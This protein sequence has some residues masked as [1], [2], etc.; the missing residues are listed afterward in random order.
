MPA[1]KGAR[2]LEEGIEFLQS[3]EV[4]V[5]PR[6]RHTIDELGLYSY[7]TDRLTNAVL[8]KLADRDNHV[9]DALRY[10]CESARRLGK[11]Q[12]RTLALP[13]AAASWQAR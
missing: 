5:H 10:A 3:F 6:C 13:E 1:V 8:P 7:E 2:S 12:P 9:I 4:V 11:L